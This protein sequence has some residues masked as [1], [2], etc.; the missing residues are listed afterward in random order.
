LCQ[1]NRS[2]TTITVNKRYRTYHGLFLGEPELEFFNKMPNPGILESGTSGEAEFKDIIPAL[3]IRYYKHLSS[4]DDSNPD[5]QITGL[6]F[7]D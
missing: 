1:I 3:Y 7:N 2:S 5:W 6:G 4:S